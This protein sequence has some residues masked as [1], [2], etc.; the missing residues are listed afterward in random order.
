MQAA[1]NVQRP[2]PAQRN[3]SSLSIG[4]GAGKRASYWLSNDMLQRSIDT[5]SYGDD[6]DDEMVI[7]EPGDDE[8]EV[9]YMDLEDIRSDLINGRFNYDDIVEEDEDYDFGDAWTPRGVRGVS[10][11][12]RDAMELEA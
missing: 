10:E 11:E 8:V 12:I 6:D 9:P 4:E 3:S 2:K 1:L 7:S 5:V